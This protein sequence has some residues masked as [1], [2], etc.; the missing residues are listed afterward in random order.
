MAK[1]ESETKQYPFLS[2]PDY[3]WIPWVTGFL[4]GGLY[5]TSMFFQ[6]ALTWAF[7]PI[8]YLSPLIGFV[9]IAVLF[10]LLISVTANRKYLETISPS[11]S[12]QAMVFLL[13]YLSALYALLFIYPV[14]PHMEGDTW[15]S[16]GRLGYWVYSHLSRWLILPEPL[17]IQLTWKL[18]GVFY[19][20]FSYLFAI[21]IFEKYWDKICGMLF[22]VSQPATL[23][24]LGYYDS[25]GDFYLFGSVFLGALY[26]YEKSNKKIW[27]ILALAGWGLS[28]F[29]HYRFYA[30]LVFPAIY[31]GYRITGRWKMNRWV[32]SLIS[33]MVILGIIGAGA[34]AGFL[35]SVKYPP[36]SL[37]HFGRL[38]ALNTK[39]DG[40]LLAVYHPF[41]LMVSFLLPCLLFLGFWV[42]IGR[43]S[44]LAIKNPVL[45]ACLYG[46][47]ALGL[48]YFLIQLFMPFAVYEMLDFVCQSGCLGVLVTIPFLVILAETGWKRWLYC[49]VILNLYLTVPN[50]IIHGDGGVERRLINSVDGERSAYAWEISPYANLGMHFKEDNARKLAC[51]AFNRG[52]HHPVEPFKDKAM[53]SLLYLTSWQYE[54]GDF[55]K[56]KLNLEL[57]YRRDPEYA[58]CM[59]GP[60]AG[61]GDRR[62][63][64]PASL[65]RV[66]DSID[67]TRNL[68]RE[69]GK[70]EYLSI[71][72]LGENIMQK[73]QHKP[74]AFSSA[75]DKINVPQKNKTDKP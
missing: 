19:L 24:Y 9:F 44:L 60:N 47:I 21:S 10:I 16:E 49:L 22:L 75:Q 29:A 3:A 71:A 56:G 54:W 66:S 23:N 72:E 25:Y 38:L 15:P 2:E 20:V 34:A 50:W 48:A 6:G 26:L 27:L 12:K 59:L 67:I 31:C 70:M 65:K 52:I 18:N 68:Y 40:F 4:M 58:K 64:T 61:L 45:A 33:L 7:D 17:A 28:C 57:M 55:E 11:P 46:S 74:N 69:T 8:S 35:D 63:Y 37:H 32:Q 62:F 13:I 41:L 36:E 1:P 14:F 42:V 5:L 73:Y 39:T 51:E 43:T 30:L 53:L